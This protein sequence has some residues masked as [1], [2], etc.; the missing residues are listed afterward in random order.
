M[1]VHHLAD[2]QTDRFKEDLLKM[3]S[4]KYP[5]MTV[6]QALGV[7]EIVKFMLIERTPE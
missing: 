6:A 1:T 4:E 5:N 2:P 3:L 7:M